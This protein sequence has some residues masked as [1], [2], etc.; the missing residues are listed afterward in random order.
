MHLE[1]TMKRL[2]YICLCVL[3]PLPLAAER[4]KLPT[5]YLSY[6]SDLATT[7]QDGHIAFVNSGDTIAL[8]IQIRRRGSS[9]LKYDKPSYAIKLMDSMHQSVDTSFLNMRKDNYWILDAM[10]C[11]V[12]RMR[13][14]AAM[15]LWNEIVPPVWYSSLEPEARNGYAG[16]MV[17]VWHD[18]IHMGLYCLTERIDRKQL[19][20]KK[21]NE[22]KGGIRGALYKTTSWD[23]TSFGAYDAAPTDGSPTWKGWEIVYPDYEDGQPVTWEP[24]MKMYD[25]ILNSDSATFA[26]NIASNID[27][28]TYITYR[29]FVQ[30]LSARDNS[31]KNCYWSFYDIQSSPKAVISV[32]DVDH[33]WGRMYNSD[34]EKTDY[35]VGSNHALNRKLEQYYPDFH[36]LTESRY[37]T[38]RSS[39]FS[40]GHLDDL[41]DS[42]FSLYTQTGIDTIESALWNNHNGLSL[43]IQSEQPY[44]HDWLVERLAFLDEL[45]HYSPMPI[46]IHQVAEDDRIVGIYDIYGRRISGQ[47]SALPT[48]IYIVLYS[49]GTAMKTMQP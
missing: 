28:P 44:I 11:D 12:A 37:A 29:L 2:I 25:F 4:E 24:L 39:A 40:I 19:K 31:G 43:D 32:W 3:F 35:N 27:L 47:L 33:S 14:R 8:P 42:Y 15:D 23:C 36:S 30:L 34:L 22:Q 1:D 18:S 7:F 6:D 45:Y 13:N 17:D 46:A 49:N 16:R 9:S 48:G 38:L 26:D 20:L 5:V 21:Y 10:A 41:L